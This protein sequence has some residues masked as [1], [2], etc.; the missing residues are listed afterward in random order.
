VES[1]DFFNNM[2]LTREQKQNIINDL[3]KKI[4]KAE[5]NRFHGLQQNQGQRAFRLERKNKAGR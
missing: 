4:E 3:E 2:P 1:T 5:V